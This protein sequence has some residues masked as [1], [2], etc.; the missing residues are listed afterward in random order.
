MEILTYI[1]FF[2]AGVA[3]AHMDS[4]QFHFFETP[5]VKLN[6]QF[7]NPA[8]S[9]KS[10]Y[11]NGNSSIGPAFIGSTTIFVFLTDGWHLMKFFRNLFIFLGM[12]CAC[13]HVDTLINTIICVALSRI[14]YG[15]SFTAFMK[16]L[17]R[18]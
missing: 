8:I 9:W 4:L 11:K 7:W 5:Y 1:L 3:E 6:H 14:I 12:F 16:I 2:L 17:L 13:I 10:K 18:N 15:L